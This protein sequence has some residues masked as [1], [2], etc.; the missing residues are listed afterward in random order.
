MDRSIILHWEEKEEDY[1]YMSRIFYYKSCEEIS[2]TSK[3]TI[4]SILSFANVWNNALIKRHLIEYIIQSFAAKLHS[5]LG[6]AIRN[7]NS[8][9]ID[10]NKI[11]IILF[12]IIIFILLDAHFIKSYANI[13]SLQRLKMSVHASKCIQI[14]NFCHFLRNRFSICM[15]WPFQ[16]KF[17]ISIGATDGQIC[18]ENMLEHEKAYFD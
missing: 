5:Y 13:K 7:D 9:Q 4:K 12:F 15:I 16:K 1:I 3:T 2:A 8:H 18:E 17:D 11:I 14:A 10:K 6:L